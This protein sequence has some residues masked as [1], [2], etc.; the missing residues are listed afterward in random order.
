MEYLCCCGNSDE[1]QKKQ[2]IKRFFGRKYK[3]FNGEEV[4]QNSLDEHEE[5]FG[6]NVTE[7]NDFNHS[8]KEVGK[9]EVMHDDSGKLS[10]T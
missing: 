7:S 10:V 6:E 1:G 2:K 5:S 3:K 8:C 4:S 9:G